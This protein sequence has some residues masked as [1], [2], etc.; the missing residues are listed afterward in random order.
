MQA[1]WDEGKVALWAVGRWLE[2]PK[3]CLVR[4][5]LDFLSVGLVAVL[6]SVLTG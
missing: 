4:V 5:V 2:G 1:A 6:Q 3:E